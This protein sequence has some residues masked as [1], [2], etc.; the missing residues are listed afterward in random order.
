MI[1]P[2]RNQD[3]Y[4]R[5]LLILTEY[6]W[7]NE[8]RLLIRTVYTKQRLSENAVRNRIVGGECLNTVSRM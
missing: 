4:F 5:I 7:H 1:M 2:L 3:V 6:Y 8:V